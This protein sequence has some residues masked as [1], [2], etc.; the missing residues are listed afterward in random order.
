MKGLGAYLLRAAVLAAVIAGGIVLLTYELLYRWINWRMEQILGPDGWQRYINGETVPGAA[1]AEAGLNWYYSGWSTASVMFLGLLGATVTGWIAA[2]PIVRRLAEF[3]DTAR[4]VQR[5]D[6][7]ARVPTD[8]R[9]FEE[10]DAFARDFN[11]LISRAER[12]E[13]ETRSNAAAI[14]HE[15]RTPLTVLQGRLTAMLDGVFP[16]DRDGL[17]ALQRQT[18]Q[19]TRLVEDLRF[20]TLFDA[21][22]MSFSTHPT[23]LADLIA[24]EMGDDAGP[25][26]ALSPVI[27]QADPARIVQVLRALLTN[28]AT[29]AGGADRIETGQDGDLAFLRVM[30]RGPGIAAGDA[31]RIF[32]RFWRAERDGSSG[33]GLGL[34]VVRAIARGHGGRITARPREGGGTIFEL[35]VPASTRSP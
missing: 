9:T 28:A 14:A 20:L 11:A 18:D 7:S 1:M 31:E 12:A 24:A 23:D 34:S 19:L 15:L 22:R 32:T 26:L 25:V 13:R 4:A 29:H 16:T 6:L 35:T 5:G 30:D 3:R 27:V 10:T 21:G 2:R 8:A 33:S 17:L